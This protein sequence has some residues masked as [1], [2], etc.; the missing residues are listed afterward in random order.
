MRLRLAIKY[1]PKNVVHMQSE[2]ITAKITALNTFTTPHQG[3]FMPINYL[4]IFYHKYKH[5]TYKPL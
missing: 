1:L 3:S 5:N 4:G 2:E